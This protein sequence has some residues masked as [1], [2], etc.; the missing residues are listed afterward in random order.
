MKGFFSARYNE[1]TNYDPNSLENQW[2]R[3][4]GMN[5]QGTMTSKVSMFMNKY[6]WK[7]TLTLFGA[8]PMAGAQKPYQ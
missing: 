2:A 4:L 8:S 5:Q 7:E 3:A 1:T 6:P